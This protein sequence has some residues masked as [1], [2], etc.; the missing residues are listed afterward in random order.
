MPNKLKPGVKAPDFELFDQNLN[1]FKLSDC[2]NKKPVVIFFYPKDQ[3]KI[4][5]KEVCCFRDKYQEFINIGAEVVGISSDSIESHQ[6]FSEKYH[7]P[8]RI[9]SDPD[10]SVKNTYG[11]SK[12]LGVIPGRETFIINKEGIIVHVCRDTFHGE[13]HVEKALEV[14]H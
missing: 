11:I 6:Q 13:F 14:L 8:F 12:V 5:T 1:K 3:T 2:F 9:L 7:L 4:C 10:G